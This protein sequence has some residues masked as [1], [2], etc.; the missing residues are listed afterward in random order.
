MH[1][2]ALTCFL[3]HKAGQ[4]TIST[5]S[6]FDHVHVLASVKLNDII[7]HF[8]SLK[9]PVMGNQVVNKFASIWCN[10]LECVHPKTLVH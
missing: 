3:V 5:S 1:D 10:H 2:D 6:N 7:S 8:H 4:G 9:K